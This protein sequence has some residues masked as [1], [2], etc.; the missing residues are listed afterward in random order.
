MF[1]NTVL[2]YAQYSQQKFLTLKTC[3]KMWTN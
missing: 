1:H 2:K 3:W